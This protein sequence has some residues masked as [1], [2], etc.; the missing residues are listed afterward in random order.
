ME[1]YG[2]RRAVVTG[3]ASGIGAATVRRLLDEGADVWIADIAEDAG[4]AHAAATG[5]SYVHLD[6][7]EEQ[8]WTSALAEVGTFDL[9]VNGAGISP[10]DTIDRAELD[11]WHRIQRIVL[12]SVFLGCR[13]GANAMSQTG[14][15]A[16][17]N[18]SSIA[19]LRGVASYTSY[20]AAKAGVRNLTKSVA[21]RC[22]RKGWNI[23]CNAV[24]PGSI[25]TPILDEQKA[26]FGADVVISSREKVI[27][28]GRVGQP[29]EVAAA[30]A[31]L[32]SDDAS[33][34]T[35]AELIVDGGR[36]AG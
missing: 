22:A 35:G 4:R 12:D 17:V 19:G 30:I 31:F 27:P 10:Q 28:M 7:T 9:L 13:H 18:I 3:G 8:S 32:G 6:V 26:Q 29:E 14:G 1:R 33:F 24:L 16:I 25:D 23:R 11:E 21:L 5:A 20:G 15:G 2:G 34:I 36:S